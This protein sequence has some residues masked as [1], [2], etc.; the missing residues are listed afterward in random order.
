MTEPASSAAAGIAAWKLGLLT[1][2][3]GLLGAGVIG[4]LLAAA[5][6]PAEAMPDR[7]KRFKLIVTQVTAGGTLSIACTPAVVRWLDSTLDWIDL[8]AC[9]TM[10]DCIGRWAEVALPVALLI[11]ALSMGILGAAV[12]LR[13]IVRDRGAA[14]LAKK[15]GLE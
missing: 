4:G 15:A 2:L 12:K 13:A 3:G 11:G 10:H 9:A 14:A 7:R 1:K 5:A 8:D 6:D